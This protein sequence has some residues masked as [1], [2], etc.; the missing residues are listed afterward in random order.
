LKSH[1][2]LRAASGTHPGQVRTVNQ[3]SVLAYVRS[4]DLGDGMGLF[5]VADGMGGHQAGE[6]ASRLAVETI[7]ENLSWMLEQD[8]SGAT[9]P[10]E[11]E[12]E[13]NEENSQVTHLER[14]L[15]LAVKEANTVIFDYAK[16]NPLK[17]GNLG[18]TATC[19]IVHGSIAAIANVGD[20]RTYLLGK[21]GFEQITNDHSYVWQLAREGHLQYEEIFD[22]PQRNVI[23]R[24][25]GNQP[26]V[27]VDSWSK[28]LEVG[29]RLFLC[30]DG[31]WE[32][33]RDPGEMAAMLRADELEAAVSQL[34]EAAN[35]YGGA[36]N[37][38]VVIAELQD[39]KG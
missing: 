36:D 28:D 6:V 17:A 14:R 39:S 27:E 2:S 18:C 8:D 26:E 35:Y 10:G 29:D 12:R 38:G 33:I 19:A 11:T 1:L 24:A 25:L 31:V 37:I 7:R 3:D 13:Q 16:Q 5:V 20:S 22:H 9:A 30:S 4:E 23:T 21:N 32:M 34:I 15:Q